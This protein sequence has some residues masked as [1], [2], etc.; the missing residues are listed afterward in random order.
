[1]YSAVNDMFLE[2]YFYQVMF[3]VV[4]CLIAVVLLAATVHKVRAQHR[5]MIL[6]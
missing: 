4:V 3:F 5:H 1:V 6:L 2:E